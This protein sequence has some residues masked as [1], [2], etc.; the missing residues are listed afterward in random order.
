MEDVQLFR[1][2]YY[3]H[4]EKKHIK[5]S[6]EE[7]YVRIYGINGT[8]SLFVPY[9]KDKNMIMLFGVVSKSSVPI[10]LHTVP[11]SNRMCT[12]VHD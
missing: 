10:M 6:V 7:N 1:P 11:Y 4:R 12:S 2:Q 8:P 5:T 9:H 3:F